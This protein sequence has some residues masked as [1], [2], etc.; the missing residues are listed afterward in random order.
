VF[1]SA[2]ADRRRQ[3][4]HFFL[5]VLTAKRSVLSIHPSPREGGCMG[6]ALCPPSQPAY[7]PFTEQRQRRQ[8]RASTSGGGG[9]GFGD[10]F[11]GFVPPAFNVAAA[12]TAASSEDPR[13][14]KRATL[15]IHELHHLPIE[16]Y[17][18]RE[19]MMRWPM[20][21]LV[22]ELERARKNSPAD[23]AKR[24]GPAPLEKAEL[25]AFYTLVPIRPRSRGERRSLRTLP[26]A[27]LRP[28]LAFNPRPRRL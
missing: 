27:S 24:D 6:N 13:E 18:T 26:G 8:Q 16:E 11:A 17:A 4:A 7:D 9:G 15:S 14:P 25:G 22:A 5:G 21:R 20:R 3:V 28:S 23:H 2:R 1:F 12:A 19:D 10:F